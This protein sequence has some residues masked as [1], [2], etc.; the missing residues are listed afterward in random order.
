MLQRLKD[1]L[2]NEWK[3][4]WRWWSVRVIALGVFLHTWVLFDPGAVLWVW[5]MLPEPLA[6]LIPNQVVAAVSVVLFL[7]ALAMRLTKQ[8]ALEARRDAKRGAQD[9]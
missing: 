4:W 5:R 6:S 3:D 2:N 1:L 7:L 8:K 9:V